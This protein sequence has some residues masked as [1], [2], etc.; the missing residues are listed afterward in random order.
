MYKQLNES[1]QDSSKYLEFSVDSQPKTM[2]KKGRNVRHVQTSESLIRI[3]NSADYES[4]EM[5]ILTFKLL[6]CLKLTLFGGFEQ[7]FNSYY[8]SLR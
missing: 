5:F 6:L 7:I 1:S 8:A 2:V 4:K 3:R